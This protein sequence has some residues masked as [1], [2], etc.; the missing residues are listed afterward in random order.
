MG[1]WK[2]KA[3][4]PGLFRIVIATTHE[5]GQV[6]PGGDNRYLPFGA[7]RTGQPVLLPTDRNFTGQ[8]L[9]ANLGL[10]YYSDGKSYGRY[11]DPAL[12]RF[13]QADPFIPGKGSQAQPVQLCVQQPSKVYGP[14]WP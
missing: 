13:I 3:A 14:G 9:D 5:N 11:Y 8:S 10:L 2:A 4:L 6:I 7:M 12:G 1:R